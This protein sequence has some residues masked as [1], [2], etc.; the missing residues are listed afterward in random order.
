MGNN[1]E[2]RIEITAHMRDSIL[3]AYKK[4]DSNLMPQYERARIFVSN[5]VHI[6][7]GHDAHEEDFACGMYAELKNYCF[8]LSKLI[9]EFLGIAQLSQNDKNSI[10]KSSVFPIYAIRAHKLYINEE[11]YVLYSNNIQST[12]KWMRRVLGDR[13][14]K[15]SIEIFVE[16]NELNMT[17]LE[18]AFLIGFLLIFLG[19]E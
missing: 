6:F 15:K 1:T 13:I 18:T 2:L 8:L 10:I 17:D 9:N 11:I 19:I 5:G 12:K 3:N 14:L 4:H 7:D 16:M